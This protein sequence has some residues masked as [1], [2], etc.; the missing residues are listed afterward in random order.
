M[1]YALV[2]RRFLSSLNFVQLLLLSLCT[3]TLLFLW[4]LYFQ[5]KANSHKEA[6]AAKAAE[7]LNLATM[8]SENLSQLVDRA[9]A[10][11]R[12]S[13]IDL[14]AQGQGHWNL[15]RMLAED[16]VLKR[17][18]LY[19]SA[20]RVLSASHNDEPPL[21]SQDW[22]T[23]LQAHIDQ[24]GFKPFLPP[25]SAE[26]Q[27][28][29]QPSWR[30]PFLLPLIDPA[31]RDLEGILLAQLDIGYL[32]ILFR[33]I[34][35]GG[36]GL[37]RLIDSAGQERLRISSSG[38]V[39]AGEPL[40]PGLPDNAEVSGRVSQF[41]D[42]DEYQSLYRRE[43][44]RGFS[45]TVS[46]RKDEILASSRLTYSRQFWLNVSMTLLILTGLFW[47]WRVLGKRQEAFSA[48]EH[49]Q[50]V[51]Q[52]LIDRLEDEHRRSSH[53]AATDHLSGLHNRRQFL[54]VAA[55][56]LAGQRT[57]RR[58]LA[59]LFIDMDRFKSINDSLGHKVGDLLL[60]AVAGRISRALDPGDEA[61]RFGGDE[62]VVLL[63]G[64]RSEEQIDA[65]VR[66]L[67]KKLSE[68]YSLDEHELNTSPSI[69]VSICPRDGQMV[70][71]LIRHADA[72]MYSAKQAGRGPT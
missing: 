48:L 14:R 71:D 58:L 53:A 20:G 10:I 35:L 1:E 21:L 38:I 4:G 59:V 56:A 3:V 64:D 6:L 43:A 34:D 68:V 51:N 22:M 42:G 33:H 39:V 30:L 23:N 72:A 36:S 54:E 61:A 18:S 2:I 50:Q 8:A 28:V 26:S 44:H 55:R 66:A 69:G 52:Q 11:G 45:V 17:M 60:Q 57:R 29:V 25:L 12:V 40:A 15:V 63:A 19:T 47:T 9:Q 13:Q 62:F 16:P 27:A 5:Q 41:F 65:W 70:D 67:V 31:K 32:A 7:H 46:Q 24:H 37:V 49:A